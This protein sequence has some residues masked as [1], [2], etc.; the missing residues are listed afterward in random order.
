[1][2]KYTSMNT[3]LTISLIVVTV[4]FL[5]S[6]FVFFLQEYVRF[7]KKV[8]NSSIENIIPKE[9]ILESNLPTNAFPT[10]MPQ[11]V[12]MVYPRSKESTLRE[13]VKYNDP[14]TEF[15]PTEASYN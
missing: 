2:N 6:V 12:I 1:M 10:Y 13:E 3:L 9:I 7:K 8:L 14:L 5:F 15:E 4:L 11:T